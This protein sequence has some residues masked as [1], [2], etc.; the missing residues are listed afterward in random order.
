MHPDPD[1]LPM[2]GNQHQ[3]IFLDNG[4]AGHHFAIAVACL[5]IGD[6]L[7]ATTGLAIVSDRGAFAITVLGN[8]QHKLTLCIGDDRHRHHPVIAKQPDPPHA[9][10]VAAT[11][12]AHCLDRKADGLAT[13]RGEQQI[14]ALVTR[15]H[16]DKLVT[17]GKLHG[18]LAI[19]L[20]VGEIAQP[21]APDVA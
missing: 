12:N 21:V 19:P 16:T 17:F 6:A 1:D 15:R 7:A 9:G 8:R 10:A 13:T 11:E 20:D 14:I 3:L 18:N 2:V 5:D 4:E